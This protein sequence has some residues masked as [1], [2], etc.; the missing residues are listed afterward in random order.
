[1]SQHPILW[2]FRRCPYAI[3]ARL[4]VK[5][6]GVCLELREIL[7]RDK[8]AA[9]LETSATATVPALRLNDRVLD[10]SLD[11]M[12]W[13]LEQRDPQC[14]LS[15]PQE[16]WD[17]IEANDGPFK[18]ALDHT[19]YATRFPELDATIERD[20]AAVLLADLDPRLRGQIWL[21]GDRPTLADLALLPFVRQFA[22]T[23][24]D[25]FEAQDWPGLI[26]WLDRFTQSEDFAQ[27][28]VKYPPWAEGDGPRWFGIKP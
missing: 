12:I 7:L 6:A 14:L 16:G 10:E 28:M 25:W 15:M 5:S 1:M 11:I 9:F 17:L 4:A 8:P 22:N 21:F 20:K 26:D 19:K 23:D 18:A 13:A 27:V 2:S 3:R 24:R